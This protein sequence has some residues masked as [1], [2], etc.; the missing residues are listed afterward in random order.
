MKSYNACHV[1]IMSRV[2]DLTHPI[3]AINHIF[4]TMSSYQLPMFT[5]DGLVGD[6]V[7]NDKTQC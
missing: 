3:I 1:A 4:Q 6:L 2:P 7:W 5:L